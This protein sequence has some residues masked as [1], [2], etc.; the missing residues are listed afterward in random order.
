MDQFHDT[1]VID[2]VIQHNSAN[3]VGAVPF[4]LR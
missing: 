4:A 1:N 3:D 2:T